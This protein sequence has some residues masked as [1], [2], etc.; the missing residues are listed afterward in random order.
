[1]ANAQV[2]FATNRM[3]LWGILFEVVFA[4]VVVT[5]PWLQ[6]VF[7]TSIP[8]AWALLCLLPLPALVWG[9]DEAARWRSRRRSAS[10]VGLRTEATPRRP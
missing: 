7:G 4:A 10:A 3:L 6:D 8:P 9:A 2:G 5:V 1:M